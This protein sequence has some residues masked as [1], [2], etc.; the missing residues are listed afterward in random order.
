[1][2]ATY[3]GIRGVVDVT[4]VDQRELTVVLAGSGSGIVTSTPSGISC[5]RV[6]SVNISTC[7]FDFDVGT[8][9]E[10]NGQAAAGSSFAGWS[11]APCAG[12]GPC[13]ITLD[14]SRTVTGTFAALPPTR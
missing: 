1:V 9:V 4:V 3:R 11:S 10:L 7:T 12:V 8:D 13:R 5:V 6:N 2:T 14:Q